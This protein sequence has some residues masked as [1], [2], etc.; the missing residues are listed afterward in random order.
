VVVLWGSIRHLLVKYCGHV[1][2]TTCEYI[3]INTEQVSGLVRRLGVSVL[4]LIIRLFDQI[5][6]LFRQHGVF[7]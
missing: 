7:I 2:L 5:L 3:H 6:E 4:P 1:V